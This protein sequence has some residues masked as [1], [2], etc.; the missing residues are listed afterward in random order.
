MM[1]E[2][3]KSENLEGKQ[4][5]DATKPI[6]SSQTAPS[7]WSSWLNSKIFLLLFGSLI[8]GILVP[9]FQYTQKT[10]EW[11]RQNQFD[12]FSFRLGMMRDCLK[13]FVY[14]ST[15]PAEA[16]QRAEPFLEKEDLIS[17]DYQEFERQYIDLQNRG[18]RQRAK[19][20]SLLISFED[21]NTMRKLFIDYVMNSSEY[22][23][24]L[25]SFVDTRH[26]IVNQENCGRAEL[27]DGGVSTLKGRLDND[28]MLLNE[29]YERVIAKMKQEIGRAEDESERFHF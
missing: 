14:L 11:K 4:P 24:G 16:Y 13:E 22:L 5:E 2:N 20:T 7:K 18:F 25:K 10:I 3:D 6:R 8:T 23:R 19:V 9:W 28:V 12:N 21:T 27:N 17:K 29:S 1:S 26:C 15:F